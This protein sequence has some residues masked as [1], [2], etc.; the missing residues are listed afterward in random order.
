M[1][2]GTKEGIAETPWLQKQCACAITQPGNKGVTNKILAMVGIA[3]T[4]GKGESS[5]T[6]TDSSSGVD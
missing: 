4:R 3:T 2:P 1:K 6:G 5:F